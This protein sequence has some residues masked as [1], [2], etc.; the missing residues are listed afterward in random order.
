MGGGEISG[1]LLASALASRG[2]DVSVLTS[3]FPGL[4]QQ[5]EVD[6]IR[7]FRRLSTGADPQSP[8]SNLKRALL[9]TSSLERE[10]P[11]LVVEEN[12]DIIHSLNITSIPGVCRV[13]GQI[14]KPCVAHINSPT[15]FCPRGLFLKGEKECNEASCDYK[16]F[17]KCMDAHGS[18][19]RMRMPSYL[20]FNP[21]FKYFVYRNYRK[22]RDALQGF[23]A[24]IPISTF[25]KRLLLREGIPEEKI[26]VIPNIVEVEKFFKVQ[27]V[28]N[29]VPRVLY[30]GQ[31][32][33][34]KGPHVLLSALRGLEGRWECGFYGSGQMKE[35]M[36]KYVIDNSLQ[37]V[38]IN[39][40]VPQQQ[41]AELYGKYDIVVFPSL[42]AEA[43]GRV[44]V[45]AL[46][47]G[48]PVCAS[49]IGG[50]TD[51]VDDEENGLLF[52]P[53]D[54]DALRAALQRLINDPDLRERMGRLGRKKVEENYTADAV[55][56]KV[57][58]VYR[59]L[60]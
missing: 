58:S 41:V 24:Y 4:P 23:D 50:V 35:E 13:K 25:I 10:L 52:T 5:E 33:Q 32:A 54:S 59:K 26:F 48:R 42:V 34:Y 17:R 39:D 46:A 30:L 21:L 56:S 16:S 60:A 45:E 47:S 44:P 18:V 1:D 43:F 55:T 29:A 51:I 9:F 28:T 36:K 27:K 19:S 14:K 6:G 11:K 38:S 7:I 37:N 22:R 53:G 20:R 12:P 31:Y 15:P 8:L 3:G 2:V 40:E 57:L 49:R